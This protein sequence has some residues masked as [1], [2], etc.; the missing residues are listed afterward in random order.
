MPPLGGHMKEEGGRWRLD[1]IEGNRIYEYAMK[2]SPPLNKGQ[3]AERVSPGISDA[4]RHL[5]DVLHGKA[6][7][8]TSYARKIARGLG[9]SIEAF[10]DVLSGAPGAEADFYQSFTVVQRKSPVPGLT[11]DHF[12]SGFRPDW[13]DLAA[14]FDIP[15]N[16]YTRPDGISSCLAEMLKQKESPLRALG[17]VGAGGAGKSTLLRRIAYDAADKLNALVLMP[18]PNW[19]AASNDILSQLRH[20][21]GTSFQPVVM[22]LDDLAEHLDEGSTLP[23][24]L[25]E[26]E[27]LAVVLLFAEHPDQWR[28]ILKK[29]PTLAEQSVCARFSVHG[30]S[31]AEAESLVDRILN[32]EDRG[33]LTPV[34]SRQLSRQQRLE[35]C[36]TSAD[37]QLV[38]AML[39]MRYGEKFR[40]IIEREYNRVPSLGGQNAYALVAYFEGL[41]LPPPVSLLLRVT[42][43]DATPVATTEFFECTDGLFVEEAESLRTRNRH[44]ARIVARLALPRPEAKKAALEQM[45]TAADLD[46][47]VELQFWLRAFTG[48]GVHRRFVTDMA[49]EAQL[50]GTLYDR[51][52]MRIGSVNAWIKPFAK[53]L[54]SSRGLAE[55]VLGMPDLA[56]QS[57]Q[58]STAVDDAYEFGYRQL[59]WLEHSQG[60][61]DDAA[62]YATKASELSPNN[63]RTRYAA[64]RILTLNRERWFAQA[65]GHWQRLIELEPYEPSHVKDFDKYQEYEAQR[66]YLSSQGLDDLLHQMGWNELRPSLNLDKLR[67]G[68]TDKHVK[69]RLRRVLTVMQQNQ[70][71]TLDDVDEQVAGFDL[72]SN[73]ALKALYVSNIA[74][75]HFVAWRR[76][77]SELSD[78]ELEQLFRN[79]IA[80]NDRDPFS[81]SWY[82]T[83]LKEVRLDYD[84]AEAQYR[85]ATEL[86]KKSDD[87]RIP[88]HPL[89][90]NNLALLIVDAVIQGQREASQLKEAQKLLENA[91]CK[92]PETAPGFFW[93]EHNLDL[94]RALIAQHRVV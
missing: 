60:N 75:L 26:A 54:Y 69:K 32:Y 29:L 49:R 42:H 94:C 9:C 37:R 65:R 1:E 13:L 36:K 23:V 91:V 87:P 56:R 83:F 33:I 90:L 64:A 89:F 55:R 52:L 7:L 3:L 46:D 62:R 18:K 25:Q 34:A 38:V 80:L 76:H 85:L 71:G 78:D 63:A 4:S 70:H 10:W 84:S 39:Q 50:I 81:H 93:P 19:T 31:D 40:T 35:L 17:I 15:R 14:D 53:Y 79:A 72:E 77:E 44:I 57:F 22:V 20:A 61:W 11:A 73:K 28:R 68:L 59:A 45:F 51:L 47:S 86:S 6:L 74:R 24:L 41:H 43:A 82:G 88:N 12:F 58:R 5:Y 21:C 67:F 8:T 27:R 66:N 30:L 48:D 16:V 2:K 92:V